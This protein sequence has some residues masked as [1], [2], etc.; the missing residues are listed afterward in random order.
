[1]FVFSVWISLLLENIT[2]K[3]CLFSLLFVYFVQQILQCCKFKPL[4]NK[5]NKCIDL[6]LFFKY[7]SIQ[8]MNIQKWNNI[9][10]YLDCKINLFSIFNLRDY[11]SFSMVFLFSFSFLFKITYHINQNHLALDHALDFFLKCL[12]NNFLQSSYLK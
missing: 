5:C 9:S 2:Q 12:K 10:F 8:P 11:A 4:H 6:F 7:S 1:M 3:L